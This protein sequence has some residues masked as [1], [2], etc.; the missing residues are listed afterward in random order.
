M[1][2][3]PYCVGMVRMETTNSSE[4][5]RSQRQDGRMSDPKG[6]IRRPHSPTVRALDIT[7]SSWPT[8][9][10][11]GRH[12]MEVTAALELA[13]S[14]RTRPHQGRCPAIP[15]TILRPP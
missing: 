15:A 11:S 1:E 4:I 10:L 13:D 8:S 5:R 7:E 3:T 2:K 6:W 14:P 9:A 12:L